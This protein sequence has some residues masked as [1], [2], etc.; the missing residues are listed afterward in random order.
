[1]TSGREN[2]RRYFVTGDG[3]QAALAI[4]T[5][6]QSGDLLLKQFEPADSKHEFD[7]D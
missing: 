5:W 3:D 7:I 4:A 2:L 1:M 6:I